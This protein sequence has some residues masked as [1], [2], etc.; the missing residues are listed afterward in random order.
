MQSLFILG[1]QPDLGLAELESLYGSAKVQSVSKMSATVDIEPSLVNF[2][3]LGGM[4]KF[5]KILTTLDTTNWQDIHQFLITTAPEH[6]SSLQDGKLRIGLS[7]YGIKTNPKELMATGLELKKHIRKSGRSVRL[8]PNKETALNSAQVLHNQLTSKLGWEIVFVRSGDKTIVAQSIAVQDIEA[9]ARRD[10]ARPMRDAKVGML[11]PKLAQIIVNLA[12]PNIQTNLKSIVLDPFCGTGVVLQEAS[13]MG[14][15]TYGSDLDQ[16]M[17]DYTKA[18]LQ[19]LTDTNKNL[20]SNS[21]NFYSLEQGDA[22]THRWSS[23]NSIATET[24]LGRP[25]SSLPDTKTLTKIIRDCDTIHTKFLKN[26]AK[27]TKPGFRMCIAVPAWKTHKDFKHLP[28]L[29]NLAGLGY[30]RT[31]FVHAKEHELIYHRPGQFVARELVVLER[32]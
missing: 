1:R 12:T 3:R 9:Y 5:C 11:P 16:K 27:Q 15:G 20:Q 21:D 10:Q 18:N 32:I 28:T 29:D 6:A 24:Y 2:A 8:V 13:L 14:Y 19:W 22:C 30:N 25:L 4:V 31:K 26:V 7:A 23:F 17:I